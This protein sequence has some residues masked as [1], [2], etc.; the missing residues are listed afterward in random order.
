[1]LQMYAFILIFILTRQIQNETR[2]RK[3]KMVKFYLRSQWFVLNSYISN[4]LGSNRLN[5]QIECAFVKFSLNV[6]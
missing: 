3:I 2:Q 1:M 6:N 5:I 4:I